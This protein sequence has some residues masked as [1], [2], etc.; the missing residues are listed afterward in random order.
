ML[1][2]RYRN[3]GFITPACTN[4]VEPVTIFEGTNLLVGTDSV[5]IGAATRD[6][7]ARKRKAGKIPLL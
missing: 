5:K 6:V 4:M 2:S 1:P 7:L 3:N